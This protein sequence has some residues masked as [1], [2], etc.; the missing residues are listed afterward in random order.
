LLVITYQDSP[1]LSRI[2]SVNMVGRRAMV[3]VDADIRFRDIREENP[4]DNFN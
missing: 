2:C 1:R 4:T 3:K